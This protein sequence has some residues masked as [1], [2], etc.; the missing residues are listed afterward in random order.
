MKSRPLLTGALA[1][2]VGLAPLPAFGQSTA[3]RWTF[4]LMPYLWLPNVDGKLNYGPPPSGGSS[5]NVSIDA[6]AILSDLKFAAMIAGEARK[7][8]WLIGTDVIYLDL[9]NNDS[10]VESVDLNPGPGRINL[11]TTSLNAGTESSLTGVVWTAVGGYAAVQERA[12]ALDVIGGFRYLGVKATTDWQLT[13]TVTG[14][15]PN[16]ASVT[17]PRSGTVEKT[18]N[19]WAGIVGAKGRIKL[20]QSDWFV[21][22]YVD[23]GG[24][25]SVFTWQGV[26]GVGYAFKWG[27]VQLDYRYLYY[28]Q[29]GDKLVQD[30]SLGGLALGVNFRF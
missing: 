1:A 19:I 12:V 11:T 27:G 2:L 20:G 9:S 25:S 22:Y 18:E 28:D 17:F 6:E 4:S 23:V 8:R 15:G 13:A 26:V 14:T 16:G 5:A 10:K 3:D 30:M 24:G 7:G 29:S 21:P